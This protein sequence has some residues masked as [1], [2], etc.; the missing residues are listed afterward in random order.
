MAK[1]VEEE[2]EAKHAERCKYLQA[3]I[4]ELRQ[5]LTEDKET[6]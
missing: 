1:R 5:K 6:H 3:R 4:M 2:S